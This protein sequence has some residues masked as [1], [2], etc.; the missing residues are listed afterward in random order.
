MENILDFFETTEEKMFKVANKI[1]E[2]RKTRG[3]SQEVLANMSG[4]SFGSIKRF[5][6]TGEIS[7]YSL[8]KIMNTLKINFDL[9][10]VEEK[11]QK[12]GFYDE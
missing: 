7:L 9:T 10:I 3:I 2:V 12:S 11:S 8:L 1:K 4:V 6:R 5:E